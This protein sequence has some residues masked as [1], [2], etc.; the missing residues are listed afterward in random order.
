LK[1]GV[2]LEQAQ[3][4]MDGIARDVGVEFPEVKDWAFVS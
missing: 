3:A 4:E 1:P 2:T